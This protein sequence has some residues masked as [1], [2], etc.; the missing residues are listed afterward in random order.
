MAAVIVINNKSYFK[1]AKILRGPLVLCKASSVFHYL[2][3]TNDWLGQG[4]CIHRVVNRIRGL[5]D[6]IA[7]QIL[8]EQKPRELSYFLS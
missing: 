3:Y 5:S 2:V 6:C 7:R 4:A 8:Q 1:L